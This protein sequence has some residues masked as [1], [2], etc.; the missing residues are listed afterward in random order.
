ML[1]TDF[2]A[3]RPTSEW[4][5]HSSGAAPELERK[6]QRKKGPALNNRIVDGY[7]R[8]LVQGDLE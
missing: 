6:A 7:S 5:V 8:F 3:V 2:V 4:R 1:D